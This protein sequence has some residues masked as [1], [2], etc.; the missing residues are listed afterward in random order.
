MRS[1]LKLLIRYYSTFLTF[2]YFFKI[3][4]HNVFYFILIAYLNVGIKFLM[5][6]MSLEICSM[7]RK[8]HHLFLN[9]NSNILNSNFR[10]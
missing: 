1:I 8:V 2:Y 3:S 9:G 10:S 5:L 7:K 4:L 6:R